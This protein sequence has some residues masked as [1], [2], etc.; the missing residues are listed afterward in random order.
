M[1]TPQAH[2]CGMPGVRRREL[3]KAG[4]AA[5]VT[6]STWPLPHAPALWAAEAGQPKRGGILRVRGV[7]LGRLNR[8]QNYPRYLALPYVLR[9]CQAVDVAGNTL[10]SGMVALSSTSEHTPCNNA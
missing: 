3:L 7:D 9:F 5:S 8:Y 10:F 4:L 2:P 6:L 1:E